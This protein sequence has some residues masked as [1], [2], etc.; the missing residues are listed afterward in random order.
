MRVL[1]I[2]WVVLVTLVRLAGVTLN[3]CLW[4]LSG[5][6]GVLALFIG[7]TASDDE[8]AYFSHDSNATDDASGMGIGGTLTPGEEGSSMV[9]R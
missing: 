2:L 5:V 1:R 3:L 6:L 9:R 7:D 4:A 8:E